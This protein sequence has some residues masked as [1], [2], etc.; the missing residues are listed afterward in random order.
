MKSLKIL[1]NCK[2]KELK[3]KIKELTSKPK[4]NTSNSSK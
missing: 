3:D 1:I 4:N 2:A